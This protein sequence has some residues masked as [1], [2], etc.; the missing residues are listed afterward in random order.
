MSFLAAAK[1]FRMMVARDGVEP[2]TPAF[3]ELVFP[4]FPTTSMVAVGLLNTGNYG[5]DSWIFGSAPLDWVKQGRRTYGLLEYWPR[6][7]QE[8]IA[9]R[10]R[11]AGRRRLLSRWGTCQVPPMRKRGGCT[12]WFDLP[13]QSMRAR[14][15]RYP[16]VEGGFRH[17]TVPSGDWRACDLG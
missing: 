4:V 6:G 8:W 16:S 9:D 13:L 17:S 14:M 2:P 15:E 3:L 10:S 12:I 1:F 5:Q 11:P 7:A